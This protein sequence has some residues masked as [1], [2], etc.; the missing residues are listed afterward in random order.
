MDIKVKRRLGDLLVQSG[1]ISM[2]QLQDAL[3]RQKTL[4]KKIGELLI[5]DGIVT[6]EDILQVLED[7]T[8]FERVN[9]DMINIDKK[10]IK[11]VPE[12][13]CLKHDLIPFGFNENKI[14]IAMWDPLNIF[15]VDDVAIASGFQVETYI[16]LKSEIKKHI[17]RYYSDQQVLR[18]AEE[19]SKERQ[20][21]SRNQNQLDEEA[22]DDIKNAPVVKMVDYLIKNAIEARASDIHIEPYEK[23]IRIRY[24]VDGQLIQISTLGIDSLAALVTRIKILAN[25]NI[26]EKR[27]PQDGRIITKV[28]DKEVDLRVS[29]LPTVSG[30]KI[31]I[32]ILDRASYKIGIDNLGMNE[33]ELEQLRRIIKNPHGIILVTGPTGSGKST[34]LYT[35]LNKLNSED[36]NIITVEDPVEY[37]LEGINQVNVNTK[38]GLTFANGLRSILRQDP[39]IVMIGEIRDNET[40]QIAIRAAITGHLVLS[41]LHTNDAPSSVTRLIDMDIEPYLVATSVVGIIA[42]RLVRKICPK[43]S[44][45]YT[46][47]AYEKH[48]LGIDENEDVILNKGSGC[49][50]CN[51]SGYSGRTGVYEI[52]EVTR[53]HKELIM[54]S[55]NSDALKDIS[56]K[57]GMKTLGT[58]CKK[59]VLNGV[60]TIDELVKTAY[61]QE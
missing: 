32:R 50:F 57:R 30:E 27:I 21:D 46:A 58:A 22:F 33:E 45:T 37:M 43:C 28:G 60:T 13:I 35:I 44:T 51:N 10:A 31:V 42:Q 59:L 29:I 56:L 23:H 12:S 8:G 54:N 11:A 41:T 39:D 34:T 49:A 48:I 38:A 14:K 53:E 15:A 7:Q 20:G 19:L 52:M 1:K 9:L 5:D 40:A 55:R 17:E 2:L 4:G 24:R 25:L 6:S 47:S 36:K 18:A 3:R 61:L 16:A 26:A